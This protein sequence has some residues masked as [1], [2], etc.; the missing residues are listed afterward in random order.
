MSKTSFCQ[1]TNCAVSE[2]MW[3]IQHGTYLRVLSLHLERESPGFRNKVSLERERVKTNQQRF[4]R[5][6][7]RNRRL[8]SI[9]QEKTITMAAP[10]DE[11]EAA[12][13]V[14]SYFRFRVCVSRF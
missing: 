1:K 7:G 5:I 4:W 14:C 11:V 13:R 2:Y 8:K 3:R 12:I 9:S 6:K 10:D